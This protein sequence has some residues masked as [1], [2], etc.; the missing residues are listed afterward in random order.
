MNCIF[1][2]RECKNSNSLRNHQRLCKLNPNRQILKSNFIEYNK[3]V[4]NGEIKPSNQFIK[5]KQL[6]LDIPIISKETREKISKSV[7]GRVYSDEHKKKISNIMK[8]TVLANPDSY[9]SNN[10]SGRTPIIEYN[11][12]KLKGSWELLVAQYLDNLSI[13]WTNKVEGIPY[14]WNNS[15]HLYFPDFYLID[16]DLFIEVKGYERERDRCKW[17]VLDNLIIF[18]KKE[19][20]LIKNNSSIVELNTITNKILGLR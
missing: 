6:G 4:K 8:A 19:I 20:D 2:N 13:K 10:V 1:C 7:K 18:K 11:G 17:K 3:R 12:F 9:S 14:E 15:I 16:Y 5:A